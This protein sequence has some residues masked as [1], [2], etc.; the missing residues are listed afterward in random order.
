MKR[1]S[2][3]SI[4]LNLIVQSTVSSVESSRVE[5]SHARDDANPS[6]FVVGFSTTRQHTRRAASVTP[7]TTRINHS[8]GSFGF[9]LDDVDR[10]RL[11]P[12]LEI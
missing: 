11:K 4:G 9:V 1:K 12:N 5:S 10:I 7:E 6:S 3:P 8:N 2:T